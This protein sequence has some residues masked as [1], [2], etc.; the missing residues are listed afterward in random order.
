MESTGVRGCASQPCCRTD[1]AIVVAEV[2]RLQIAIQ[3][4]HDDVVLHMRI[5]F[6]VTDA[7]QLRVRLVALFIQFTFFTGLQF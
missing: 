4:S 7:T 6:V 2:V 5:T 3:L 1:C